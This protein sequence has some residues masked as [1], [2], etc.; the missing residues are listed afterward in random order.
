[1]VVSDETK[2]KMKLYNASVAGRKSQAR[3]HASDKGRAAL[4]RNKKTTKGRAT[5]ARAASKRRSILNNCVST[6]TDTEWEEIQ[7]EQNS[8]CKDCDTLCKLTIDHIVPL[9]KGGH[10][11]KE[12]I[13]GLCHPC[14]SSKGNR[15]ALDLWK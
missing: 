6:L 11:I 7:N 12:N 14:N 4:N 3:Y 1:M 10:H 9:S 2:A 13:Q 8:Q 15:I 5:K